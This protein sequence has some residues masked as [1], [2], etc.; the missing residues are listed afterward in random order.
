MKRP[1]SS[2]DDSGVDA[3]VSQRY[4]VRDFEDGAGNKGGQSSK[5]NTGRNSFEGIK[6]NKIFIEDQIG[7]QSLADQV[8]AQLASRQMQDMGTLVNDYEV[9][10]YDARQHQGRQL[11]QR[12]EQYA[13]M[14]KR[15]DLIPTRMGVGSGLGRESSQLELGGDEH[16]GSTIQLTAMGIGGNDVDALN[17]AKQNMILSPFKSPARMTFNV[18]S[19]MAGANKPVGAAQQNEMEFEERKGR[20]SDEEDD[21]ESVRGP[22][23][24]LEH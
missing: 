7:G 23:R 19:P 1:L 22:A 5:T 24:F 8:V 14:Q 12:A 10:A 20:A 11:G 17:L 16:H 4:S 15:S 6:K 21:D 13:N 2:S 18:T 3:S 9:S